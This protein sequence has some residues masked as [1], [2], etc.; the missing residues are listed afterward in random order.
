MSSSFEL[1][2]KLMIDSISECNV[3]QN[4]WI[5]NHG[6]RR[7]VCILLVKL[8]CISKLLRTII[9]QKRKATLLSE[10]FQNQLSKP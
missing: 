4:V 1:K 8:G 9:K 6:Y 5:V 7:I 10:K 2:S 3:K